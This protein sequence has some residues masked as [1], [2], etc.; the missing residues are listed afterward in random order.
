LFLGSSLSFE[1]LIPSNPH[2]ALNGLTAFN[3]PKFP[4]VA[5]W[6]LSEALE[7]PAAT[8]QSERSTL[9]TLNNATLEALGRAGERQSRSIAASLKIS[10]A[11]R[12]I[13][14]SGSRDVPSL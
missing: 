5:K 13:L 11:K 2:I 6:A 14:H 12:Y 8:P 1:I 4:C 3:S 7:L 10:A 9:E